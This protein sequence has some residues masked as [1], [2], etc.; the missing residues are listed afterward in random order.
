MKPHHRYLRK[1]WY[2]AGVIPGKSKKAAQLCSIG[3]IQLLLDSPEILRVYSDLS[4]PHIVNQQTDLRLCETA[5]SDLECQ[6]VVTDYSEYFGEKSD[7]FI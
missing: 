6:S 1:F 2:E 7:V 4:G 3:W 5:L